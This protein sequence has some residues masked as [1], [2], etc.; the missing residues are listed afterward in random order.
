MFKPIISTLVLIWFALI[1]LSFGQ[2][3]SL[4]M[5]AVLHDPAQ[6]E[7]QF[8]VGKVDGL[9]PLNLVAEGLAEPQK[10]STENGLLNLYSSAVVDKN[11]PSASLA[12]SVKVPPG[13]SRVIAII[14]PSQ[15]TPPYKMFLLDDDAGSFPWGE[16]KAV[17]LT[18]V[19]FAVEIGEHKILVPSGKIM[20]VPKV[21]KLDEFNRAQTN[22]YYKN[23][24]RW[25]VAAERQM[26]YIDTLRRVFL[27]YKS[28][29]AVGPDVRTIMDYFPV[30]INKP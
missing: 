1:G 10:I 23:E 8:F 11:N 16:S 28:Q 15:G 12:A 7:M 26:Q 24:D 25:V 3:S 13:A 6:P 14:L 9:V 5:R 21:K 4:Q 29:N 17:N 19:D 20:A 30:T 18:G 27:I 22:F 2:E